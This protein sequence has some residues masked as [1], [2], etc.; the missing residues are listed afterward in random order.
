MVLSVWLLLKI[1][2][3]TGIPTTKRLDGYFVIQLLDRVNR[4]LILSY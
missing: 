2:T 1:V 4:I 3:C